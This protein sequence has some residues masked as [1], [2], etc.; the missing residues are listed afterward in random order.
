MVFTRLGWHEGIPPTVDGTHPLFVNSENAGEVTVR[1]E[2]DQGLAIFRKN[3][4][5]ERGSPQ[6]SDSKLTP[7]GTGRK[8]QRH[9]PPRVR[10][11]GFEFDSHTLPPNCVKAN[12]FLVQ[13]PFQPVPKFSGYTIPHASGHCTRPLFLRDSLEQLDAVALG[14]ATDR[15]F[16][17]RHSARR[18]AVSKRPGIRTGKPL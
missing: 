6:N 17:S 10:N 2:I 9:E 4:G 14:A 3:L 7:I 18:V 8:R 11:V 15:L 16:H 12:R 1:D 13:T 5:H